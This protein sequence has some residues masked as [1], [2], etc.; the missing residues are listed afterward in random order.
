MNGVAERIQKLREASGETESE[1]AEAVGL[2]IYEYGDLEAYDDEII[3]VLRFGTANKV[4]GH[5]GLSLIQ[6]LVTEGDAWPE[7]YLSPEALAYLVKGKI[8]EEGMSLEEAETKAGWYLES[9][10]ENP[11]SYLAEQ[12]IMFLIDLSGFLDINWLSTI[13]RGGSS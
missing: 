9:F 10:L 6:L 12:P 11:S 3:N 1:V 8:A 2:S 13:P 4:A 7:R 5:F